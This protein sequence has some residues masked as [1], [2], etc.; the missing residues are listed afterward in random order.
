MDHHCAFAGTCVGEG[1]VRAFL[2]CCGYLAAASLHS[3]ALL[4]A[5]DGALA[6]EALF[7]AAGEGEGAGRSAL[8]DPWV[9]SSPGIPWGLRAAAQVAATAL[10]LPTTIG[11]L[12][13]AA[14]HAW[15]AL[16]NLTTIEFKEGVRVAGAGVLRESPWAGHGMDNLEAVCGL[17][18]YKWPWPW[19]P[20]MAKESS[21]LGAKGGEAV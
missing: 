9:A 11:L 21:G 12:T 1:N 19:P 18:V 13:L 3:L 6:W 17:D 5:L 15:L 14:W 16:R 8:V 2:C 7:E 20:G 4:L 10:A